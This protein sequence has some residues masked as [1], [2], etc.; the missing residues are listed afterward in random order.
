MRRKTL[1]YILSAMMILCLCSCGARSDANTGK[2]P[3]TL[4]LEVEIPEKYP[5]KASTY[6]A[7]WLMINEDDAV[8]AFF[9]NE[10][11]SKLE[12]AEGPQFI[13]EGEAD[14]QCLAIYNGSEEYGSSP[15]GGI[16]YFEDNIAEPSSVKSHKYRSRLNDSLRKKQLWELA[17][18]LQSDEKLLPYPQETDLPGL[19]LSDAVKVIQGKMEKCGFPEV[20]LYTADSC[21][22][23]SINRNREIYNSSLS[24]KEKSDELT[25]EIPVDDEY[26]FLSF[27]QVQDG[28]PLSILHWCDASVCGNTEISAIFGRDGLLDMRAVGLFSVGEAVSTADVISPQKALDVFLDQ[29]NK[30]IHFEPTKILDFQLNYVSIYSSDGMLLR[31]A[32]V[33][34]AFTE[35]E[36]AYKN[37]VISADT[38]VLLETETDTR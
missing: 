11:Q 7:E 20:Q 22:A 15:M 32:W 29:Y 8:S 3:E 24:G 35:S 13:Y 18:R 28:I 10:P 33:I 21:D 30:A 37:Y 12:W 36:N 16:L 14:K 4:Q 5:K 26:F 23:E 1:C 34:S 2:I 9:Q 27:R 19:P 38:G 17:N 31:P 6:A 25:E